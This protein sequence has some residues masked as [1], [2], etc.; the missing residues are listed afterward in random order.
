MH[1]WGIKNKLRFAP[2][3]TKLMVLTKKL[4][5]DDLVVYINGDQLSLVG[6]VRLLEL[7]IDKKL[8]CASGVA[9]TCKK[10]T[11]IYKDIDKSAK[12]P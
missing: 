11:K 5:Y 4:K 6:E 12:T 7:I 10:A 9:K 3:K 1:Y 2:S 8:M